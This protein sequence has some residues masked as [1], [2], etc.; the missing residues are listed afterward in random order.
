MR[1]ESRMLSSGD[2]IT[3]GLEHLDEVFNMYPKGPGSHWKCLRTR[4]ARPALRK[5]LNRVERRG[6]GGI[7][8]R[9]QAAY[10]QEFIEGKLKF[11]FAAISIF[12]GQS[13]EEYGSRVGTWKGHLRS[14]HLFFYVLPTLLCPLFGGVKVAIVTDLF[15]CHQVRMRQMGPES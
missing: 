6:V 13:R 7:T 1:D 9:G 14:D 10:Q 5:V 8:F 2:Q 15:T 3:E 12:W 4:K 11:G